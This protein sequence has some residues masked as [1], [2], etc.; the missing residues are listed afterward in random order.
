MTMLKNVLK[1]LL[2]LVLLIIL[3]FVSI[4]LYAKSRSENTMNQ[5][6]VVE[7]NI[8]KPETQA[9]I[10]VWVNHYIVSNS[11]WKATGFRSGGM[12]WEGGETTYNHVSFFDWSI[13]GGDSQHIIVMVGK[14]NDPMGVIFHA[15]GRSAVIY[16]FDV[17]PSAFPC[18]ALNTKREDFVKISDNIYFFKGRGPEEPRDRPV[19]GFNEGFNE[20]ILKDL[21]LDPNKRD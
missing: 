12:D 7:K 18:Y 10:E 21:L 16:S 6:K 11:E 8:S 14:Y 3:F 2:I 19:E 13:L 15:A 17:H 4:L 9:Y 5:V 1:A 20:K